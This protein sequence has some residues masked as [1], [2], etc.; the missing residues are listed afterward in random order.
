M[1]FDGTTLS[2]QAAYLLRGKNYLLEHGWCNQGPCD[3]QGRVC[4]MIAL[5]EG[6]PF[7]IGVTTVD[8]DD[9]DGHA[10]RA[11][12]ATFAHILKL[13]L[14]DAGLVGLW[15]DTKGRTLAEV[16]AV[17]DQAIALEIENH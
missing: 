7:I 3:N 4:M 17:Y 12:A 11:A 1:P 5:R 16:L 13:P 14:G 6:E 9:D 15:N 2:S 10:Y 8:A